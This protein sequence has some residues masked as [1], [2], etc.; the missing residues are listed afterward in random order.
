MHVLTLSVER[1]RT[2]GKMRGEWR[3]CVHVCVCGGER[4]GGGVR[5]LKYMYSQDIYMYMYMCMYILFTCT[6]IGL[7]KLCRHNFGN[8]RPYL[9]QGIM[10]A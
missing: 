2:A 9:A 6:C 1:D 5:E 10:P 8:N 3:D 7:R 4:G